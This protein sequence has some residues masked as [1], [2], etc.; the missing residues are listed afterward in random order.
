MTMAQ[1]AA[2]VAAAPRAEEET[3]DDAKLIRDV[4]LQKSLLN[5]SPVL[6]QRFDQALR[7]KPESIGIG[8]FATQFWATR[9]HLLRSHAA[10]KAQGHGTYNVLSVIKSHQVDGVEH[11]S[12]TKEQIQLIFAQHPLVKRVYNDLVPQIK[13]GDFWSRFFTTRLIKKLK[14]E[15][16]TDLDPVDAKFDKYLDYDDDDLQARHLQMDMVPRFIDVAGNEQNHSQRQGNR[17]DWTMQPNSYDKVPILRTLNRMSEKMM[18]DVPPSDLEDRHAPAGMDEQT[19]KELQ[20]RDLQLDDADNR[21]ILKIKD[22]AQLFAAEQGLQSSS[23]AATYAQRTPAQALNIVHN[24]FNNVVESK[25]NSGGLNLESVLGVEGDSSSEEEGVPKKKIKVGS[26][27]ARTAATTQILKA[28]KKRHLHNDDFLAF[29]KTPSSE[30]AVKLGLSQSAFETL[31]MT[32][33]TTVEFLHYFWTVYYSGDPDRASEVARLI[34]TLEKSLDRIKAV[35]DSAESERVAK[36]EQITRDYEAYTKRT[37]KKKR[38][39]PNNVE[40]GAKAVNKIVGPLVRAIRS[41]KEHFEK[42][43]HEQLAQAAA[44]VNKLPENN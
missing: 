25:T 24:D 34:E 39:D 21:V 29:Q 35:A 27:S 20:L 7:D 40:G 16:I 31:C 12:I 38:F 10:E 18:A 30:Q 3:Y 15:K 9:V 5:S 44:G 17:P 33:N 41:A 26:R 4:E 28:I 8:Q 1:T 14:G 6:R 36:I 42:T 11:L 22:Q 19:Y 43:L 13:E 23:S 32:H 37:G 2:G